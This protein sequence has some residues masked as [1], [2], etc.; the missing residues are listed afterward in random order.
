[1]ADKRLDEMAEEAT[2]FWLARS[3]I[4]FLEC[5]IHLLLT[6]MTK[7]QVIEVLKTETEMLEGMD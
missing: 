4:T 6:H 2:A 7:E 1:M 3:S 5:A